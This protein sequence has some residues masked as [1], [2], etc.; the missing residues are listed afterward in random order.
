MSPSAFA[1]GACADK[2]TALLFAR[3][4]PSQAM[5]RATSAH[6][7]DASRVLC[8]SSRRTSARRWLK[9]ACSDSA[10]VCFPLACSRLPCVTTAGD[11]RVLALGLGTTSTPMLRSGTPVGSVNDEWRVVT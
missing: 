2:C 11:A 4:Q 9:H 3:K 5:L 7:F 8:G 6:A 1:T 10:V